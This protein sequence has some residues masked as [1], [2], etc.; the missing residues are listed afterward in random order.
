MWQGDFTIQLS[1]R[2]GWWRSIVKGGMPEAEATFRDQLVIMRMK[3]R[4]AILGVYY[5]WCKLYSVSTDDH[6]MER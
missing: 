1:W 4:Q 2:A 5:T 3:G 6:D